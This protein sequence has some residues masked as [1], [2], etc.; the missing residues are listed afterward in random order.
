MSCVFDSSTV[1]RMRRRLARQGTAG[2]GDFDDRV[3]EHGRLDFGC[4]PRELDPYIHAFPR[5]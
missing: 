3:G 2:L 1:S 5:K 4:A